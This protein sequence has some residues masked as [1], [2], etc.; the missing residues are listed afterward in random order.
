MGLCAREHVYP[1]GNSAAE[2]PHVNAL[3]LC[4]LPDLLLHQH[5]EAAGLQ[6]EVRKIA[7][8]LTSLN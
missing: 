2:L 5:N 6:D 8:Y 3:K 1:Q 7:L 4:H